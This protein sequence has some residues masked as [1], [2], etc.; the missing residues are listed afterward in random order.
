MV[1]ESLDEMRRVERQKLVNGAGGK[2]FGKEARGAVGAA[3]NQNLDAALDKAV[4]QRQ[5][6]QA[7]S[8]TGAM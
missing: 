5:K 7:F 8:Q 1:K 6:R 4:D 2:T 3:G